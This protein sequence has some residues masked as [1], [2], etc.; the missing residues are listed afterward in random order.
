M[1]QIV[2]TVALVI[3]SVVA[4]YTLAT[5]EVSRRRD[6]RRERLDKVL[7][8]VLD[9]MAAV[10]E[11]RGSPARTS[12][13]AAKQRLGGALAIARGERLHQGDLLTRDI[14]AR[15]RHRRAH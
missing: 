14:G 13:G 8:R 12:T 3:A 7:E 9:L 4:V 2:Q 5:S 1:V 10:T 15:A 11:W 6:S